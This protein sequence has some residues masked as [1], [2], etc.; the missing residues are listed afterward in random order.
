MT[1]TPY[2]DANL[3]HDQVTGRAVTAWVHLVNAP[4]SPPPPP[5]TGTSNGKAQLKLQHLDLK[6]WQLDLL[7]TKSLISGTP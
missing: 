7:Q 5:P 3:H 1:T 6:L 4:I 2:I